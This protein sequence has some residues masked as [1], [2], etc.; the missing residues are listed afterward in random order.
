MKKFI[1]KGIIIIVGIIVIIGGIVLLRVH[2]GGGKSGENGNAI[3]N[4]VTEENKELKNTEV[5]IKVEE[6][7]I[8]VDGEECTD[9]DELKDRI[10]KINSQKNDIKYVFEH[11][12]AIKAT[13][14]EVKQALND[15]EKVLEIAID[16]E[17]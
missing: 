8:Y 2:F 4:V 1:I 7:K 14:D 6:S 3:L 10:K 17:G 12:Y 5:V 15:L 9:V 11:E 16:D 13:Y